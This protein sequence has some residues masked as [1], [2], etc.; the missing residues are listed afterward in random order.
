MEECG[1]ETGKGKKLIQGTFMSWLPL[2]VVEVQ[3]QRW[4]WEAV[5]CALKSSHG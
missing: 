5:K 3:S 2:S 4:P 1:S